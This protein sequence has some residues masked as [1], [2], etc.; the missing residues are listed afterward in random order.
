MGK[1]IRHLEKKHKIEKKRLC[2]DCYWRCSSKCHLTKEGLCFDDNGP[3]CEDYKEK[4]E[5]TK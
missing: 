5:K 1:D 4:N 3:V 2:S